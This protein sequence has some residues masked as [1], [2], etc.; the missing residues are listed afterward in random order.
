MVFMGVVQ[1][2]Q[3]GV[4]QAVHVIHVAK[5]KEIDAMCIRAFSVTKREEPSVLF[6]DHVLIFGFHAVHGDEGMLAGI[7]AI[8]IEIILYLLFLL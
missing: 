4:V 2:C 5:R 8:A 3:Q 6:A 1:N 7:L